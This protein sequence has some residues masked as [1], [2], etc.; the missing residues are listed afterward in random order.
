MIKTSP[1]LTKE[2]FP[3]EGQR[4]IY[5]EPMC[6]D[7]EL[8]IW[9]L[10]LDYIAS[11]EPFE[12]A[13]VTAFGFQNK[14]EYTSKSF[15]LNNFKLKG[16]TANHI[17]AVTGETPGIVSYEYPTSGRYIMRS[18]IG[19]S[20]RFNRTTMLESLRKRNIPE[21]TQEILIPEIEKKDDMWFA[22]LFVVMLSQVGIGLSIQERE[23]LMV[24]IEWFAQ[25]YS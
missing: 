16:I 22:N 19:N 8:H 20:K 18:I 10:L 2:Q 25:N 21:I 17:V 6:W 5:M 11:G 14:E 4:A 9:R 1:N 23:Q 24:N 3:G 13:D 15:S 12:L 7:I